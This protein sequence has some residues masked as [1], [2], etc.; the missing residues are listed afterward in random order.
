MNRSAT[1]ND[2]KLTLAGALMVLVLACGGAAQAGGIDVPDLLAKRCATCHADEQKNLRRIHAQR[3]TPEGW[4]MTL[5]RMQRAHGLKLSDDERRAVVKYLADT[6]GLAPAE[7]APAR[8]ALERRLNTIEKLPSEQFAQMCARCHSG[9]RVLLQRRTATEWERLVHFHLAQFPTLE[10]QALSRDRDWMKIAFAEVAPALAQSQPFDDASWKEW[11]KT[12]PA[13]VAGRWSIAGRLPGKGDFSAIMT[14]DSSAAEGSVATHTDQYRLTFTGEYADGGKMQGRGAVFIYTGHEWRGKVEINGIEM[15]Q[16]FSVV[17]GALTGRMFL[18]EQDEVGADV[19]GARLENGTSRILAVQ[20]SWLR[21]GEATTLVIVGANLNGV[22]KLPAG[23]KIL[24][25]LEKSPTRVALSVIAEQGAPGIHKITLGKAQA[26]L[27]LF[28]TLARIEV[29]PA[30][31]VA[32]VGGNGGS[33]PKV[34]ARFEA[35]GWAKGKAGEEFRVGIVPAQW[36]LE[37]FNE[38][39]KRDRDLAF[40]G[41]IDAANGVF[42]PAAAGPNPLRHLMTNNAGNL[43]VIARTKSAGKTLKA[44]GQ[45]IVTVQRWVDPPLP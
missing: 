11:Q 32:R 20:P 41:N 45:L 25:T 39:A 34:D 38:D 15:R 23:V 36:S 12:K 3:K 19:T 13:P 14:L 44:Q 9:A 16:V 22:P 27:A 6:Q 24:K 35:I 40:A 17:D 28:E 29:T 37:P 8:Y 10:Y 33:T 7:T 43:A 18:T 26:E 2:K 4:L 42:T 5:V 30:Y 1:L 21:K 31:A